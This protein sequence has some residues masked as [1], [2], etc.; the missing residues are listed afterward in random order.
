MKLDRM[1]LQSCRKSRESAG[2]SKDN[3]IGIKR[4]G[5]GKKDNTEINK[6]RTGS[7]VRK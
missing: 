3:E 1:I 4:K 5:E 2:G 7:R 6:Q